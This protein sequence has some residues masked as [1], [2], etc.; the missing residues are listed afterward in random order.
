MLAAAVCGKPA[1]SMK[2]R[3]L[4]IHRI[5]WRI[6]AA[7]ILCILLSSCTEDTAM[8]S[9]VGIN[10]SGHPISTFLVNGYDGANVPAYGG[11]GGFVCCI[12]V[13]RRW[14]HGLTAKIQWTEAVPGP[15]KWYEALVAIPHYQPDETSFFAVHFYEDRTVKVLVTNLGHLHPKYPLPDPSS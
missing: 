13:P 14:R 4:M 6:A 12:A 8:P 1:Q 7:A 3:Y 10:Y 11:G 5:S 15:E 2:V 9:I